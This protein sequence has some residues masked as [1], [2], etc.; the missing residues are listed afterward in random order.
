MS[1]EVIDIEDI[2]N[3]KASEVS[4]DFQVVP[5]GIWDATLSEIEVK[6]GDDKDGNRRLEMTLKFQDLAPFAVEEAELKDV[7]VE[8]LRLS[9]RLYF[10][11][12]SQ[13]NR[14]ISTQQ[15]KRYAVAAG[16]ITDMEDARPMKDILAS[17]QNGTWK[18]RL[19]VAHR[20]H[21]GKSFADVKNVAKVE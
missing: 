4:L 13:Q 21:D 14:E 3:T 19:A 17:L 18:V 15:L 20:E 11:T 12:V 10:S 2:L 9:D 16:V 7:K 6:E 1:D 5:V 8:N